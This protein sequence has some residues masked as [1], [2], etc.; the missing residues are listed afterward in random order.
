M[1][2]SGR[3]LVLTLGLALL[4]PRTEATVE[5]QSQAKKL[6]FAVK[7]CLYCHAQP[8]ATEVMQAKA[9]ANNIAEGN[10]L[11]CHGSKIPAVLNR[12]GEWLVAQKG[13][14]GARACDMAWL[15]DYKEPTPE[16]KPKPAPTAVI[17][18]LPNNR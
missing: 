8:H 6:G 7:N 12:R 4:V 18:V 17:K 16:P 10:C 3:A 1:A 14:R 9:R 11:A 13:V 5:M 2:I 15:V